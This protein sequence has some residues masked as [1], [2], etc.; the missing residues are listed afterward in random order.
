MFRDG[1]DKL[2]VLVCNV[3]KSINHVGLFETWRVFFESLGRL[4]RPGRGRCNPSRTETLMDNGLMFYLLITFD[5]P[6]V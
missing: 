3:G 5:I 6:W 4:Q 2:I 1:F